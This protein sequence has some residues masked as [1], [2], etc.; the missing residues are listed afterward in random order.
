MSRQAPLATGLAHD[1]VM[2][3]STWGERFR[4]AMIAAGYPRT[5]DMADA[6]GVSDGTISEWSN[7]EA[8][9]APHP[10]NAQRLV[11]FFETP[12]ARIRAGDFPETPRKVN[13]R[14]ADTA[15]LLQE[16][17]FRGVPDEV[18]ETVFR[19][20]LDARAPLSGEPRTGRKGT[21]KPTRKPA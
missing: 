12:L 5:K 11:E 6:L 18:V 17:R 7:K 9:P 16:L 10:S 20:V 15:D 13:L 4:A 8:W 3:E 1:A 14:V 21:S 2:G 19:H